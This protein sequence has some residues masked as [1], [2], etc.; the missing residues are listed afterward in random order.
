MQKT[1]NLIPEIGKRFAF[2]FFSP[3]SLLAVVDVV[4]VADVVVAVVA[5]VAVVVVVVVIAASVVAPKKIFRVEN[6]TLSR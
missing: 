6:E 1:F 2:L 3:L 4:V 5:D